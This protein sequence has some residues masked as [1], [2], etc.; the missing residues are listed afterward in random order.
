M[1]PLDQGRD[2]YAEL[3][4]RAFINAR[5]PYT[6]FGGAIMAEEVVAAMA[7]ASRFGV[8]LGEMQQKVGEAIAAMT[9]NE[10]A[11][12]SCGAASGITLAIAACMAAVDQE[13]ADQ[14]PHTTGM[15]NRILMHACDRGTECDVAIRCAGARLESFGN[16]QGASEEQLSMAIDD[17]TAA[18]VLLLGERLC[19]V[20]TERVV[21]MAHARGIPVLMDGAGSVP[22][23]ENFWRWTRATDVDAIVVSG[24]KGIGGPQST[25]LVLGKRQMIEGC[26]C[27]GLPN[28]RLGRGMKVG[29][30]ELAGIYAAV[31]RLMS[32]DEASED[33]QHER[34]AESA[35][36]ALAE[37]GGVT[38][39]RPEPNLV[40]IQ[41]AEAMIGMTYR[42]AYE[43]FL[44][45]QPAVLMYDC[46][47]GISFNTEMLEPGQERDIIKHFRRLLGGVETE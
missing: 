9:N 29:K 7:S 39:T 28:C 1:N 18:I 31:K 3:G 24:G 42:E 26:A 4:V 41:F 27:H 10:A 17:R 37:I 13:L 8:H 45:Q 12:I 38:V 47:D 34:Q 46:R 6:R 40:H 20:P 32:I 30:E 43:W 11:Y 16:S 44:F 2:I 15:R 14:L 23:R 22:P 25:G 5:A 21:A 35:A 33:A 36:H 19:K